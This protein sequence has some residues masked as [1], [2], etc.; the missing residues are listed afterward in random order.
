MS[1]LRQVHRF[2]KPTARGNIAALPALFDA[3]ATSVVRHHLTFLELE[4]SAPAGQQLR[5]QRAIQGSSFTLAVRG[6][7]VDVL[8]FI[9]EVPRLG[10]LVRVDRTALS[11]VGKPSRTA[12]VRATMR[13]TV[14]EVRG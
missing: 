1:A 14:Y 5:A 11:R 4:P 13:L 3:L 7:F 9:G 2:A 6:R 12:S 8:N 10:M